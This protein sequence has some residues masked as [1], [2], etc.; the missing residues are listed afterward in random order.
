VKPR[1]DDDRLRGDVPRPDFEAEGR[2]AQLPVIELVAGRDVVATVDAHTDVL[3]A[4]DGRGFEGWNQARDG[5]IHRTGVLFRTPDGHHD[6]LDRR[7]PRRQHEAALIAVHHDDRADRPPAEAPR[8]AVRMAPLVVAVEEADVEGAGEVLAEVV[9]RA[10]LQRPPIAHEGF[11]RQGRV[12]AGELLGVA[13]AAGDHRDRQPLLP[14]FAIDIEHALGLLPGLG[15]GLMECVALLPE[16]LSRSQERPGSQLPADDVGPLVDEHRQVAVALDLVAIDLADQRLGGRANREPLG[17]LSVA[18]MGDPRDLRRE[19]LDVLG[20]LEQ[21]ALRHE[22]RQVDV[23]V[24]RV[25]DPTVE[26]VADALPQCEPV[27]PHDD[28]ASDR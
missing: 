21:Q 9:A 22:Q 28:A 16:K 24:S 5:G 2:A 27:R 25:L 14:D 10:H 20:L 18:A 19:A 15:R 17:Q 6:H 3:I 13:L 11:A 4:E 12:G 1:G 8:G 7:D 26:R 23:V